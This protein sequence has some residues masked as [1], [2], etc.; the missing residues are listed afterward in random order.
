MVRKRQA[1]INTGIPTTLSVLPRQRSSPE[2][3]YCLEDDMSPCFFT[4]ARLGSS[5]GSTSFAGR[6]RC[7]EA[8]TK[9]RAPAATALR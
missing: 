8:L 5:L 7:G 2:A 1:C 4:G 6:R 9:Q 3:L